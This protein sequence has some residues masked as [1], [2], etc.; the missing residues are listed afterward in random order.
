MDDLPTHPS[1]SHLNDRL[2]YLI[3]IDGTWE[4]ASKMTQEAVDA[5]VTLDIQTHISLSAIFKKETPKICEDIHKNFYVD[6]ENYMKNYVPETEV[7]TEAFKAIKSESKLE[8]AELIVKIIIERDC[9][10]DGPALEAMF[11]AY[12]ILGKPERASEVLEIFLG[13]FIVER[14]VYESFVKQ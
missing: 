6:C 12:N 3:Q 9:K 10:M 13:N 2:R 14:S 7:I 4:E 8:D 1:A 11:E 5:G